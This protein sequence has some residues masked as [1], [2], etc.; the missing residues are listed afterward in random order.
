GNDARAAQCRA[1][2]GQLDRAATATA[3]AIATAGCTAATSTVRTRQA[4]DDRLS[5]AARC[6]AVVARRCGSACA[7]ADRIERRR[8]P[9]FARQLRTKR[10]TNAD[11]NGC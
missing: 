9:A 5:S 2:G 11:A 8:L 7:G 10:R 4:D 1:H 3:T 6:F